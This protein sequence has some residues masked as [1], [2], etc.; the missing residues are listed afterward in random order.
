MNPSE[1]DLH[2][3]PAGGIAE[4]TADLEAIADQLYANAASPAALAEQTFH[5]VCEDRFYQL[6]TAVFDD[7]IRERVDAI[8]ARREPIFPDLLTLSRRDQRLIQ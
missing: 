7:A 2:L 5:A 1:I 6:T 8:L 4:E 3:R